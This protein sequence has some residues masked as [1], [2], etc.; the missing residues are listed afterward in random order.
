MLRYFNKIT[1]TDAEQQQQQL[2]I[3]READEAAAKIRAEKE[4]VF[5][6][7][8]GPGRPKK[9]QPVPPPSL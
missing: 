3:S 9:L 7:K 6:M 1:P 5:V 2:R 8:R 4:R